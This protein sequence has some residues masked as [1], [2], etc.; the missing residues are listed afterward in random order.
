MEFHHQPNMS[1]V[2]DCIVVLLWRSELYARLQVS[3]VLSTDE[4]LIAKKCD[5]IFRRIIFTNQNS[6]EI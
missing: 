6:V 5:G 2:D 1:V 3:K 4:I